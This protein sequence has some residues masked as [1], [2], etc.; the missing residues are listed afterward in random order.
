MEQSGTALPMTRADFEAGRWSGLIH[1]AWKAGIQKKEIKRTKH[2]ETTD[3]GVS[4][5]TTISLEL[6][7]FMREEEAVGD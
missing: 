4:A 1:R 7:A 3:L 6:E 2:A 5:A